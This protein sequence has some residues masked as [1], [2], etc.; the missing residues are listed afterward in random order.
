MK[1]TKDQAEAVRRLR[2]DADFQLFM[3][4][5]GDYAELLNQHLIN[6]HEHIEKCQGRMQTMQTILKAVVEV[7]KIHHSYVKDK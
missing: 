2:H 3:K 7:D 5:L 1:L 6:A 4:A